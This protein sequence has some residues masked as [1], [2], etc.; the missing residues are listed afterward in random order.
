MNATATE[1]A[2]TFVI[3]KTDE[4][5]RVCSPLTP[6][7]QHIV[8]GLPDAPH[9]TCPEFGSHD[10]DPEYLCK[11]ILAVLQEMNTPSQPRVHPA[12]APAG[13]RAGDEPPA[14]TARKAPAGKNGN[15]AVM[16]LKR[17]ISPD[18]RIDS[19][20]VEFSLPIGK[21]TAEELKT[22]AGK[23]LALQAD[24]AQGFLK[25]NSN[26]KNAKP[27]GNA[28]NG[29][30]AANAVPGQMLAVG[31]M[32]GKW[33]KR[34]FLNILVNGQ[35]LKLFGSEKQLSGALTDAG[36]ADVAKAIA[37]GMT[38]NLPCRVVTKPSPDGKYTN[39]ERVLPAAQSR[40]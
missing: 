10:G 2:E 18:G 11:H 29:Q 12:P 36:Y 15:G 31:S 9:C 25:T 5:F 38:F 16:L 1:T 39:I 4:G 20:S 24:I 7:K 19:L 28:G 27:A 32:N 22:R 17:S 21:S 8:T 34:L 40:R 33:G 6:A 35:V 14:S 23:I 37:D 26:G 3:A 30:D 13:S